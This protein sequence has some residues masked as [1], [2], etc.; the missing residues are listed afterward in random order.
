MF[1]MFTLLAYQTCH[2][3]ANSFL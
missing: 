1:R 3:E 2:I